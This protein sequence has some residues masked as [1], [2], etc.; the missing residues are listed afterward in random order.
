MDYY[1]KGAALF[2]VFMALIL[3]LNLKMEAEFALVDLKQ[4]SKESSYLSTLAE[5]ITEPEAAEK[6][7]LKIVK[8]KSA[9]FAKKN[10]YSSVISK[11]LRYKGG[12]DITSEL[13]REIDSLN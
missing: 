13:A 1:R 2:I 8:E 10:N 9:E 5:E 3:P 7:I 4:L 12:K 6:E 11:H